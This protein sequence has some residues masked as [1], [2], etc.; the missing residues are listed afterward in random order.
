MQRSRSPAIYWGLMIWIPVGP[1]PQ[2]PKSSNS[3]LLASRGLWAGH[4]TR[5]GV[6]SSQENGYLL[7]LRAN[8]SCPGITNPIPHAPW[9]SPD[10]SFPSHESCHGHH[11]SSLW[12]GITSSCEA[13]GSLD[14]TSAWSEWLWPYWFLLAVTSPSQLGRWASESYWTLFIQLQNRLSNTETLSVI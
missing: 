10:I 6:F 4:S 7:Y 8:F 11:F 13:D 3:I 9:W 2:R 14:S 1:G 12:K 5:R